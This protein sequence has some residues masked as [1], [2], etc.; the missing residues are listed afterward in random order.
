MKLL[1]CFPKVVR[2]PFVP[3]IPAFQI[4]SICIRI[5]G[6]AP[7]QLSLF[8]TAQLRPQPFG[9]FARDLLLHGERVGEFAVVLLAPKLLVIAHVQ[10]L[11]ANHQIVAALQH[12]A[13]QDSAHAQVASGLQRIDVF[14]F[15]LKD[16]A[17]R[18]DA[19]TW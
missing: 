4:E 11:R 3:V 17:A 13:G 14:P 10:L 5:A 8:F 6:I 19:Q 16:G 18:A 2:G 12:P 1:D 7:G 15:V 9:N